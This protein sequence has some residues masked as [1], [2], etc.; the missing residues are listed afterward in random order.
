MSDER[1]VDREEFVSVVK[2][3]DENDVT[4]FSGAG[5]VRFLEGRARGV[6]LSVAR[7]LTEGRPGWLIE[8]A[9]TLRR[10]RRR[11]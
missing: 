2:P 10:M 8:P 6:P 11:A 4:Y 5:S 3:A 7:K 1:S 9:P